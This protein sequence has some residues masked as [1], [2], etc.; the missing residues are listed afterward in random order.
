KLEETK[1]APPAIVVIDGVISDKSQD[2]DWLRARYFEQS[3]RIEQFT[4]ALD[5]IMR[6]CR[7]TDVQTKRLLWIE[8]R[9]QCAIEGSEDWREYDY[10]KVRKAAKENHELRERIEQLEEAAR[11]LINDDR[12]CDCAECLIG[13][14][15]AWV[16]LTELLSAGD[17]LPTL[18]EWEVLPPFD[19]GLS[20]TIRQPGEG[21]RG[22]IKVREI[23]RTIPAP[24]EIRID[25][26]G[27][28]SPDQGE[29]EWIMP[30][31]SVTDWKC[32]ECGINLEV[33]NIEVEDPSLSRQQLKCPECGAML[34]TL[35]IRPSP[36]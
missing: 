3:G 9:A 19:G 27:K 26:N 15:D 7:N 29:G 32:E 4:D 21:E 1:H 34:G 16:H 36:E 28:V 24:K 13:E 18:R 6:V 5:H 8:K 22:W 17:T 10:P 30:S 33:A 23:V 11:E 20:L 35:E 25:K 14:S 31:A 12:A 2:A